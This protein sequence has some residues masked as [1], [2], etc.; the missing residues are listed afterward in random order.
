VSDGWEGVPDGAVP[1]FDDVPDLDPDFELVG[2]FVR[3][4]QVPVEGVGVCDWLG[5]S[6]G[7][8]VQVLVQEPGEAVAVAPRENVG[9]DEGEVQLGAVRLHVALRDGVVLG[10][11]VG[12]QVGV[13]VAVGVAD[14]AVKVR[15]RV[16]V[17]AVIVSDAVSA[18]DAVSDTEGLREAVP[19]RDLV[20]SEGVADWVRV[21]A[22]LLVWLL[23]RVWL[24]LG[25]GVQDAEPDG[26]TV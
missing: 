19:R 7:L 1:D 21:P 15:P 20:D 6:V 2:L 5:D 4:V 16:R 24:T 18:H 8:P 26:E 25:L 17:E 14:G 12:S 9:V 10:V 22:W 11:P 23:V 13:R 3:R